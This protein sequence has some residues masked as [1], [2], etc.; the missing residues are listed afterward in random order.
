[1]FLINYMHPINARNMEHINHVLIYCITVVII[2]NTAKTAYFTRRMAN[3]FQECSRCGTD[4]NTEKITVFVL[5]TA[6]NQKHK[7]SVFCSCIVCIRSSFMDIHRTDYLG[8]LLL[9]FINRRMHNKTEVPHDGEQVES[10][11]KGERGK[12]DDSDV[13]QDMGNVEGKLIIDRARKSSEG[14]EKPDFG[15]KGGREEA[16]VKPGAGNTGSEAKK[17]DT[18]GDISKSVDSES[19]KSRMSCEGERDITKEN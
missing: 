2:S 8:L 6:V 16:D 12:K 7:C 10:D 17:N 15:G 18:D 11:E 14:E 9:F 19:R 5:F 13:V 1:V 3:R 4:M